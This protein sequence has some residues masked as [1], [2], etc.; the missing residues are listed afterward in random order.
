MWGGTSNWQFNVASDFEE[1][2]QYNDR[3]D[4]THTL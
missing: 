1:S 3:L 4:N 2:S